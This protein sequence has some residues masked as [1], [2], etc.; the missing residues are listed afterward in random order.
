MR[1]L[2]A[3]DDEYLAEAI[4]LAL[5][6]GGYALDKVASGSD[7]DAAV[8]ASPYDLL[9]LDLGL[10]QMDGLEVL[11][12]LRSRG[13]PVPVLILTAR[14]SLADRVNG[15]DL[16]ANDYLTKPFDLPEL[17]ARIRALIRKNRWDNQT[18]IKHGS[19]EFDTNGRQVTVDNHVVELSARELATL[20]LL[21][22]RVGK[23]VTKRQLS[24]HLS[25]W[26]MEVTNNAIEI[27]I[28]RLRKKL[29]PAGLSLRRVFV[30]CCV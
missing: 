2:L 1:I 22:Q 25:S 3:E 28:H 5:R 6:D 27:I 16:G 29:E 20:E 10:P 21:L 7:A 14:D 19:I 15:L 23:V 8:H 17:E 18:I 13:Q 12:R 30:K 26:E 9:I 4:A 24:E 11:K